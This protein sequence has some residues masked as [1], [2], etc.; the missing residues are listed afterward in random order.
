[1]TEAVVERDFRV[2]KPLC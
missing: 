2:L 1:L